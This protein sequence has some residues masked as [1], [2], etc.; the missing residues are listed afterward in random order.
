MNEKIRFIIEEMKIVYKNDKRPWIIGYSGG[1]DSTTVVQLVFQML[2]ELPQEE[3]HKKV[4]VVSSDTLVENPIILTH[5]H[6]SSKQ[7]HDS[8][9]EKRLPLEAIIVHPDYNNTFW[10]NIIGKGF[11]TPKSSRFRWCTERLKITPSNKFIKEK[12][13]ENGEAIVLLGV[14]KAE[15][16]ARRQSIEKR[17]I[18]GYLLNP[19]ATL[20]NT[21]VYSPIVDLTVNDVWEVLL[22][23]GGIS[24]WGGNNN[25]LFTLYSDGDGGECPF[26][27]TTNL[28][29]EIEAPSCGNTR[30]GCW[31][32]TVVKNDK[33]LTGFIESGEEWLIPL[34]RF[35]EWL[36]EIRDDREYRDKKQRNGRIYR[37][38][39]V[40]D[41]VSDEQREVYLNEGYEV[42]TDDKGR[43][44]FW[45]KGLGPFNYE[46]RKLILRELLE[47]EEEVGIELI[48]VEELKEIEKIW[49]QEFDLKRDELCRIYREVKNKDLPWAKFIRPIFDERIISEINSVSNKYGVEGDLINRLLILTDDNKVYKNKT[50]YRN[51]IDKLLNQK[52]LHVDIYDEEYKDED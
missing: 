49:N 33:S 44:F 12:V 9:E 3:R 37:L 35:R 45:V 16:S 10:T 48:S 50:N 5:L 21:Y 51:S 40:Y 36:L 20:Y 28:D 7:I 38:K 30:F 43:K 17:K 47:V 6:Q 11:P 32:C 42:R 46:G 27:L 13:E 4:Y 25:K 34:A 15:S 14:R 52:W 24:P 41:K 1:K 29:K 8:A 39:V 23:N 2:L 31:T 22:S 26:I 19:H 18:D